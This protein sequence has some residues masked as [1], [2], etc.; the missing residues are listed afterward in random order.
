[1]K[2]KEQK[3][4]ISQEDLIRAST[5]ACSCELK[6][7]VVKAPEILLLVPIIM[8]ETWDELIKEV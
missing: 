2:E 5:R 1:M 3:I 7:M 6:E 4:K 8:S